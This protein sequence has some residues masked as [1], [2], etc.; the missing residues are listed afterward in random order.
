MRL[1]TILSLLPMAFSLPH[2]QASDEGVAL[3]VRADIDGTTIVGQKDTSTLTSLVVFHSESVANPT[4]TTTASI[5]SSSDSEESQIVSPFY[6]TVEDED[7]DGDESVSASVSDSETETETQTETETEIQSLQTL[8][9]GQSAVFNP[10]ASTTLSLL[11]NLPTGSIS[12]SAAVV[13]SGSQTGVVAAAASG[14][15]TSSGQTSIGSNGIIGVG[16]IALI[17]CLL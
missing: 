5:A 11:S 4:S 7:D 9:Q 13:P 12:K 1:I 10:T 2:L 17:A 16:F 14:T 3:D 6:P 8:S 15:S